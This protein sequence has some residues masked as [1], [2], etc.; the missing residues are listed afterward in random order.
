MS[1]P[2]HEVD[3][4]IGRVRQ[5]PYGQ[6]RSTAA[7]GLV[8]EVEAEGPPE[9]LAYAYATLVEAYVWGSE[10]EKAFVPF[11][12][13]L[14]WADEHPEHLDDGDWHMHF[15]SF[16]WMVADLMEYPAVPAEQIEQTLQDMARRYALAGNGTDAVAHQRYVWAAARG[17]ADVEAAYDAWVST[18]RDDYSQCEACDPGDRAAHLFETGRPEEGIRLLER[19]LQDDPRCATEPADMLSWLQLA[20]LDVGRV[21]DAVR[22]HR[23]ALV[24]LD[25]AEGDL[26]GARGRHVELLARTGNVQAAVRRIEADQ[27]W[28]T[29]G[30][31]PRRRL[32][33]LMSVGGA[34]QLIAA[35]VPD[36]PVTLSEV[37]ATTVAELAAWCLAQAR[38]LADAFDLRNGTPSVRDEMTRRWSLRAEPHRVELSVLSTTL[39]PAPAPGPQAAAQPADPGPSPEPPDPAVEA[40]RLARSGDLEAAAVAYQRAAQDAVAAGRLADAGFAHAEAARC[41]QLVHDHEGAHRAYARAGELLRAGGVAPVFRGP[42]VRAWAPS[43]VEVGEGEQVLS[44]LERLTAELTDPRSD[45]PSTA[46]VDPPAADEDLE[47]RADAGRRRE[48]V[49]VADTTA[50]TLGALGRV[51]EAARGAGAAAEA[52]AGI[53]AIGDAAH[54]FW[55]AGRLLGRTGAVD[56]AVWHLESAVEGFAMLRD[57]DQQSRAAGDLIDLLREHG[58]A[59]QAD[60]VARG[61]MS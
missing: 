57:R 20:Y 49:D 23:R 35:S 47:R 6:A 45:T 60:E 43:A 12:R 10:V 33:L 4:E 37:P 16:K 21:E 61:L 8:A 51:D 9:S 34:A 59:A 40:E 18:A 32:D 30:T 41:A 3:H 42:V 19:V 14:R 50:R 13:A 2:R 53:G 26:T 55:L 29:S 38:P 46:P 27:R 5:M 36:L 1:R 44:E 31:T 58:R 39:A 17:S 11:T 24:H 54:A 7:Q 52:Y 28:L 25:A 15:W 22:T 48:L 56:E